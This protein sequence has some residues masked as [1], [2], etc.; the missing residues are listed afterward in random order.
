MPKIKM[1][2]TPRGFAIGEFIDRYFTKCSIQ[3]SS[4]AEEACIWLGVDDANPQILHGDATRLGIKH[5]ATCGWIKYPMPHEVHCTTRMHLTQKQVKELLPLLQH[6]V[7][8][9]NLPEPK[10]TRLTKQKSL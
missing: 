7:E 6:F 10:K 2:S 5:N 3:E 8:T 9:G 4:N 1:K